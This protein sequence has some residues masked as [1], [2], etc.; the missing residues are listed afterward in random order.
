MATIILGILAVLFT[1]LA[2]WFGVANNKAM[3]EQA[4]HFESEV[5]D[6]EKNQARVN[7]LNKKINKYNENYAATLAEVGE[8]LA[9]RDQKEAEK[10]ELND[11][12]SGLKTEVADLSD[13]LA[14]YKEKI[15][16]FGDVEVL[17]NDLSTAKKEIA[18]LETSIDEVTGENTALT[19]LITQQNDT[20]SYQDKW[21]GNH[22]SYQ[23]QE[24]LET[25]VKAVYSNWGFVVLG[26]GDIK[27][28]TP[29]SRLE[30]TRGG[31]KIAE[32][33]VKTATNEVA[34][35]EVVKGSIVE[36]DYVRIGDVVRA[37][38]AVQQEEAT[39]VK[40]TEEEADVTVEQIK[41]EPAAID[42]PFSN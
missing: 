42:D 9:V 15:P 33:I 19:E 25:T 41:E 3:E 23:A 16:D 4:R 36:G 7:S 8:K 2:L 22:A 1:I 38:E 26:A 18:T 39:E 37:K 12:L 30:V 27:G 13:R 35:A 34:T 32:L 5:K 28:V 31:A 29:K 21:M 20:I 6:N 11:Q 17:I 24:E 40:T 10:V 14:D